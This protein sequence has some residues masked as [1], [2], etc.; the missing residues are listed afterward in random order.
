MTLIFSKLQKI[1]NVWSLSHSTG[2]IFPAISPSGKGTDFIAINASPSRIFLTKSDIGFPSSIFTKSADV[3]FPS[4][5]PEPLV[6]NPEVG[7]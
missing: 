5:V 3:K 2:C 1:K 4:A 7:A 6:N